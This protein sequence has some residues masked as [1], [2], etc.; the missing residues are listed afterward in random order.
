MCLREIQH[1]Y[2]SDV[3][4]TPLSLQQLPADSSIVYNHIRH[5]HCCTDTCRLQT[6]LPPHT[7]TGQV[8]TNDAC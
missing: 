4:F 7:Y 6:A 3:N 1:H 2:V 5:S 8:V